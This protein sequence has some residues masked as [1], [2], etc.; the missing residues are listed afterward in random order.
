MWPFTPRP[1]RAFHEIVQRLRQL[2]EDL[3]ALQAAHERLRGR[4]YASRPSV[5]DEADQ[6]A[7]V[8]VQSKAE[9]L[10]RFGYIPGKPIPRG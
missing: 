6:P 8:S 5:P 9:I 7:K 3:S 1:N 4:F 2:E 10:R